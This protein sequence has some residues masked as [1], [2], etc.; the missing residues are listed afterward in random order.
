[1]ATM[2]RMILVFREQKSQAKKRI[3][4]SKDGIM[5][6]M[7]RPEEEMKPSDVIR[8]K[9]VSQMFPVFK[10]MVRTAILK[11]YIDK[12]SDIMNWEKRK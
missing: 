4:Y 5:F 2:H 8:M 3:C 10:H 7:Y 12:Q 1:M 9:K 11:G 6:Q